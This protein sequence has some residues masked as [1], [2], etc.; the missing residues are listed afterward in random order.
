MLF[1]STFAL[2][3]L[4]AAVAI[5]LPLVL[6][7][8]A[9]FYRAAIVQDMRSDFS[10]LDALLASREEM[11]RLLAKLPEPGIVLGTDNKLSQER[12]DHARIGYSE[13]INL[14]LQEHLDVVDVLFLDSSGV[15]R[16]WLSRS[17][18]DPSLKPALEQP[19]RPSNKNLQAVL[20]EDYK[21]ICP[22]SRY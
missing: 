17:V 1:L 5:N 22:L 16:F 20:L 6:D 3:P 11:I 2:L 10:D 7:R 13:W 18:N 4:I 14:I 12:I 15:S 19:R 9:L 8:V 21:K